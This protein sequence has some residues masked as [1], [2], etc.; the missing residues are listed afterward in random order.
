DDVL[1]LVLEEAFGSSDPATSDRHLPTGIEQEAEPEGEEHSTQCVPIFN[2]FL[3]ASLHRPDG[4]V[5]ITDE[6][7]SCRE[8]HRV[9][10]GQVA[11]TP[12]SL[13]GEHPVA[14]L[15]CITSLPQLDD[16]QILFAVELLAPLAPI[17]PGS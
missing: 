13:E 14:T 4:L 12:Q 3:V 15:E 8:S 17:A 11:R 1:G 7:S 2:S 5:S 6:E 10:N 9:R 16:R